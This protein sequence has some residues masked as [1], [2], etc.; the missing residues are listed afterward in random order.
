[1]AD[2]ARKGR[3][4]KNGRRT[5]TDDEVRMVRSRYRQGHRDFADIGITSGRARHVALHACYAYV[6]DGREGQ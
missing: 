2:M 1:M 5:L 4:Y 6:D 3:A